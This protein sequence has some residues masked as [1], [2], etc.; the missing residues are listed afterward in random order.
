MAKKLQDI[1]ATFLFIAQ[2]FQAL[3]LNFDISVYGTKMG[4]I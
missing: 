3:F 4:V 1:T 2:W